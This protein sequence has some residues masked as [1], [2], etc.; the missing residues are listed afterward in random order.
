LLGVTGVPAGAAR[1]LDP[2]CTYM[3]FLDDQS[4]SSVCEQIITFKLLQL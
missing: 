1:S 4:T 3:V 2:L